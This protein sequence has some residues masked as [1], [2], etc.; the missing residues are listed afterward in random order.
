MITGISNV[1]NADPSADWR[2]PV[3]IF[4]SVEWQTIFVSSKKCGRR[5]TEILF[6]LINIL[7]VVRQLLLWIV[8]AK[9]ITNSYVL[10]FVG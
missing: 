7:F 9:Q 2:R 8:L 5:L 10:L 6:P 3:A 4:G 1:W